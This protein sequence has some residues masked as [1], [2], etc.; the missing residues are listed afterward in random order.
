MHLFSYL[1]PSPGDKKEDASLKEGRYVAVEDAGTLYRYSILFGNELTRSLLE[2]TQTV[3]MIVVGILK[4]P[5]KRY[6]PTGQ[7]RRLFQGYMFLLGGS[8]H[9]STSQCGANIVFM[10]IEA[11]S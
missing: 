6:F 4:G 7:G 9:G 8:K 1:W 10:E 3:P 11:Q 5:G 2:I